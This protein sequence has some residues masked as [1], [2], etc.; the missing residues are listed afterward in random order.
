MPLETER[1]AALL[2]T[3]AQVNCRDIPLPTTWLQGLSVCLS[4]QAGNV[5][6]GDQFWCQDPPALG[7]SQEVGPMWGV[8]G[9]EQV[10]LFGCAQ[11]S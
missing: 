6:V 5:C 3:G 10:P 7:K 1:A 11:T 9:R 2:V 8:V 4:E